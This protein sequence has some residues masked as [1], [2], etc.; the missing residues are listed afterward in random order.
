MSLPV[1]SILCLPFLF[2][3]PP[4]AIDLMIIF[5]SIP[6][7]RKNYFFKQFNF[8]NQVRIFTSHPVV[9][10]VVHFPEIP[11]LIYDFRLERKRNI[12]DFIRHS[13]GRAA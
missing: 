3:W 11:D 12:S 8:V 4:V 6:T 10:A 13:S 5:T 7:F 2:L 1:D 9:V